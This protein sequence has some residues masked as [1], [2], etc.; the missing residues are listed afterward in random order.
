[1][2][3]THG[4]DDAPGDPAAP[5]GPG[6]A[7]RRARATARSGAHRVRRG[8]S[9]AG[10]GFTAPRIEVRLRSRV[11]GAVVRLAPV[12]LLLLVARLVEAGPL[13][14]LVL[15]GLALVLV[16]RPALPAVAGV[17]LVAGLTVAG[18]PDLLAPAGTSGGVS[19]GPA[20]DR[21]PGVLGPLRLAV[22]VLALD[23]TVR[24]AALTPHVGWTAWVEG[25]V[26]ARLGRA[27]LRTQLVVQPVL[28]L[29]YGMRAV[30]PGPGASEILR[31]V[32][33]VAVAVILGLLVPRRRRA[34]GHGP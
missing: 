14:A 15:A 11:P 7:W 3:G 31:L 17:V 20:G 23:V 18:G 21:P 4:T 8:P 2:T 1:M 33:L 26:L 24:A 32:A 28:W 10:A 5:V 22:V 27:V 30:A 16:L 9:P 34:G 13:A 12:P 19:V 25:S 29:A 6:A